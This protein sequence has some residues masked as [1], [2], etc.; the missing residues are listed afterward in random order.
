ME[1]GQNQALE[2]SEQAYRAEKG[3][4]KRIDRSSTTYPC[5][6]NLN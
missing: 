5:L 1:V 2:E 6:L 4:R 3:A